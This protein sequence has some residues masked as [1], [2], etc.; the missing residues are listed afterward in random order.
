MTDQDFYHRPF[1]GG[2][3]DFTTCLGHVFVHKVDREVSRVDYRQFDLGIEISSKGSTKSS[4]ELAHSEGFGDVIV[5]PRI[6]R[7][8]FLTLCFSN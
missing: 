5:R 3:L 2:E 8:N 7:C 1:G 4:E 6:E